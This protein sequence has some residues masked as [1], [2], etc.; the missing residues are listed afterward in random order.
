M[1]FITLVFCHCY[2]HVHVHVWQFCVLKILYVLICF[3]FFFCKVLLYNLCFFLLG[4][5]HLLHILIDDYIVHSL[6]SAAEEEEEQVYKR[7]IDTLSLGNHQP[8]INMFTACTYRRS[9]EHIQSMF[10]QGT[11][12]LPDLCA[13]RFKNHLIKFQSLCFHTCIWG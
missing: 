4:T 1:C 2:L 7:R 6:E 3:F 10:I 9:H 5:F 11:S 8:T 13:S 12:G